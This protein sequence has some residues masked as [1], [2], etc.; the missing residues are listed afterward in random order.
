M[1]YVKDDLHLRK[2]HMAQCADS[3][4]NGTCDKPKRHYLAE[5]DAKLRLED[6]TLLHEIHSH[7]EYLKVIVNYHLER[8]N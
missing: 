5:N 2:S 8:H 7:L 4:T 3:N 6:L 1:F